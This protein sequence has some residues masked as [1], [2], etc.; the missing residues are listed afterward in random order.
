MDD[1]RPFWHYYVGDFDT[2]L[3]SEHKSGWYI[4]WGRIMQP[5]QNGP[6][7]ILVGDVEQNRRSRLVITP[8]N[9][10]AIRIAPLSLRVRPHSLQKIDLDDCITWPAK[11]HEGSDCFLPPPEALRDP[12]AFLSSRASHALRIKAALPPEHCLL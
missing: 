11:R 3:F 8:S 5:S 12:P 4:D 1:V 10:G 6:L 2:T 9:C 7:Y